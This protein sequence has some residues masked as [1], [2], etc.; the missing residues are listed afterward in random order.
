MAL[1]PAQAPYD[2]KIRGA[3]ILLS[4]RVHL[5]RAHQDIGI[6][7]RAVDAD[8]SDNL[9]ACQ[10]YISQALKELEKINE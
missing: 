7:L 4:I 1:I 3:N 10:T 8:T 2:D 5:G 6:L 9:V